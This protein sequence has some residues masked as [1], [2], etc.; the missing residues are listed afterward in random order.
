V[1]ATAAAPQTGGECP[2]CSCLHWLAKALAALDPCWCEGV[3]A[4]PSGPPLFLQPLQGAALSEAPLFLVTRTK[5][6]CSAECINRSQGNMRRRA[7]PGRI[8]GGGRCTCT[9]ASS[10][11]FLVFGAV[12][13]PTLPSPVADRLF[14]PHQKDLPAFPLHL[15]AAT[16]VWARTRVGPM[17]AGAADCRPRL[18]AGSP[19]INAFPAEPRPRVRV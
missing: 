18:R 17:G 12:S 19:A 10:L 5:R 2:G 15:Y 6:T 8:T 1:A 9:R 11:H 14:L 7:T 13:R 16:P 4:V 3:C